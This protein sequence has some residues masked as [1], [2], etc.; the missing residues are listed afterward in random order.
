MD[1]PVAGKKIGLLKEGF[2][3]CSD[4][5]VTSVVKKVAQKLTEA[6]CTMKEICVPM[7]KD[8]M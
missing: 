1:Q 2:E 3:L 7:H 4:Q 5:N 6:G 8:G